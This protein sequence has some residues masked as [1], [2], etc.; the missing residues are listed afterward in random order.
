MIYHSE[1][2]DFYSLKKI[3]DLKYGRRSSSYER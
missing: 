1:K 3:K 2:Q